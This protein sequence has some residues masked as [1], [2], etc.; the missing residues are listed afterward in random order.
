MTK[1]ELLGYL[2]EIEGADAN[3]VA[4]TFN[5][6][7]CTAAMALLRLTRQG[8]VTRY[9]DP[10]TGGYWYQLT[11]RGAARLDFLESNP[12]GENYGP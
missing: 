1:E 5:Q 7:Y 12:P 2:A 11:E 4:A 9:L 6:A 10:S 8:L 3:G